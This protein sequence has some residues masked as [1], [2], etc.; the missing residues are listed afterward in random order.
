MKESKDQRNALSLADSA[1]VRM[2]RSGNESYARGFLTADAII[3]TDK[4]PGCMS[5]IYVRDSALIGR[6]GRAWKTGELIRERGVVAVDVA[7]GES[8]RISLKRR[9]RAT[10][11]R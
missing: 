8:S 3:V 1:V 2:L 5:R 9:R 4:V 10:S 6:G 11:G 7:A